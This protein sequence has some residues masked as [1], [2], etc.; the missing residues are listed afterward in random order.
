MTT[1]EQ[2]AIQ[3]DVQYLVEPM[4][5][6][7]NIQDIVKDKDPELEHFAERFD[8]WSCNIKESLLQEYQESRLIFNQK[9]QEEL[10]NL[11]SF[12]EAR[13]AGLQADLEQSQ[14]KEQ[15][16]KKL[17]IER[18]K[19]VD[20]AVEYLSKK[21]EADFQIAKIVQESDQKVN[22]YVQKIQDLNSK[23]EQY[24]TRQIQQQEE[25]RVAFLRGVS[26]L[27]QEAMGIFKKEPFDIEER[28]S[29]N[30][31]IAQP[32]KV[33]PEGSAFYEDRGVV[34]TKNGLVT[35]HHYSK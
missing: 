29:P 35:R 11:K 10:S 8:K 33:K 17:L 16:S 27:N 28:Y 22:E 19:L 15:Q 6:T 4:T 32:V 25:M 20:K 23:M 13:I 12:Y 24:R 3:L 34:F 5:K 7:S 9:Q 26:A 14:I 1:I 2:Q 31:A 21:R 18:N 30:V